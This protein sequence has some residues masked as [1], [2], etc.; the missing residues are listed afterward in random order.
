MVACRTVKI[1]NPTGLHARPAASFVQA[2]KRFAASISI[3]KNGTVA[4]AKSIINVLALGAACGAVVTL[5][6]DG[7]DAVEAVEA[8]ASL[9]EAGLGE[10]VAP[11]GDASCLI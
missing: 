6:A 7:D 4:D 1:V 5:R 11:G 10:D 8:L 2:A 3:E 9:I